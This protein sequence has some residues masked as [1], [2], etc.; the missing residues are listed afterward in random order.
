MQVRIAAT[1]ATCLAFASAATTLYWTLGGTWLLDTVGGSLERLARDRGTAALLLGVVVVLV[2]V[3]AGW[4]A[5]ALATAPWRTW[6]LVWGVNAIAAGVLC[7]WGGVNVVAGAL[8]LTGALERVD[9]DRHALLWHVFLWD[10]W[11]L[12]WGLTLAA[13]VVIA[14]REKGIRNDVRR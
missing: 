10:A 3:V 13:A 1:I 5:L 4:C 11:F 7:L 12:V 2:K 8:V 9:A 14:A 6:R